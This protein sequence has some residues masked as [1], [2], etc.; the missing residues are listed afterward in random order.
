MATEP[1]PSSP[2]YYWVDVVAELQGLVHPD[3]DRY[4]AYKRLLLGQVNNQLLDV[5]SFCALPQPTFTDPVLEDFLHPAWADPFIQCALKSVYYNLC[6]EVGENDMLLR[7]QTRITSAELLSASVF[8]KE[9][10]PAPGAG[11][12]VLPLLVLLR[13]V[14]ETDPYNEQRQLAICY[15]GGSPLFGVSSVTFLTQ[16][17]ADTELATLAGAA[18]LQ[19]G[20]LNNEP[21]YVRWGAQLT[22]GDGDLIADCL[23]AKIPVLEV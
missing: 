5:G 6:Q 18:W 3:D 19:S 20:N 2:D 11:F 8:E 12:F 10:V 7:T 1:K 16:G 13:R 4:T 14:N 22:G 21:I 23:Y 17:S 9:I 15:S